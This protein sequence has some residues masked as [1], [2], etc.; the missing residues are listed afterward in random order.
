M[1]RCVLHQIELPKWW[2]APR[3]YRRVVD[4]MDL[5]GGKLDDWS[6]LFTGSFKDVSGA[7]LLEISL[8]ELV[9][10]LRDDLSLESHIA[11]WTE[12]VWRK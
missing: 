5:L 2:P 9:Q 4:L 3:D 12:T 8:D 1:G 6:F 11:A 10:H 7:D